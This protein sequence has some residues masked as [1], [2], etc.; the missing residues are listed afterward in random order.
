MI[1]LNTNV[2]EFRVFVQKSRGYIRTGGSHLNVF[3]LAVL[4]GKQ[5]D[6]PR[7]A[8]AP[9]AGCRVGVVHVHDVVV[10]GEFKMSVKPNGDKF[11]AV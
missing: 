7:Q 1:Q 6:N 8:L 11:V 9:G 3:F 2:T 5:G 10:E 4:E